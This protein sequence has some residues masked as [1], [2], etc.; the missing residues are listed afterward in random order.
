MTKGFFC[1]IISVSVVYEK[2][3]SAKGEKLRAQPDPRIVQWKN[4]FSAGR[5]TAVRFRLRDLIPNPIN[6]I[7]NLGTSDDSLCVALP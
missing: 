3:P 7:D 2:H 5:K 1:D 4:I 6:K